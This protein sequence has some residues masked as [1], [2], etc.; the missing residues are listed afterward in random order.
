MPEFNPQKGNGKQLSGQQYDASRNIFVRFTQWMRTYSGGDAQVRTTGLEGTAG[1]EITPQDAGEAQTRTYDIAGAQAAILAI[2]YHWGSYSDVSFPDTLT[3]LSTVF[4]KTVGSGTSS[5][6]ASQQNAAFVGGGTISVNPR[7]HAQGSAAILPEVIPATKSIWGRNLPTDNY[8]FYLLG[9]APLSS[10]LGRVSGLAGQSATV[11]TITIATPGVVTWN[12]NGLANGD[13]VVFTTTGALP[14]GLL[15]NKI[16]YVV[17]VSTNTFQVA[18]T[19]GGS[20]I[21][22]TGT[23]SGVQTASKGVKQFPIFKTSDYYISSMGQQVSIAADADSIAT[24]NSSFDGSSR[25]AS[26]AYGGGASRETGVTNRITHIGPVINGL[27]NGYT[28]SDSQAVT[29]VVEASTVALVLNGTTEVT[30]ITNGPTTITA[31]A[32]S[33]IVPTSLAATSV[34]AVPTSGLYLT[35]TNSSIDEYGMLQIHAAV[36]DFSIF[37]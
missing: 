28:T 30:A 18:L 19:A 22:T 1:V 10:I 25:A 26:Y 20:A 24:L 31:T 35:E 4:N 37:A 2:V 5:H 16:Y 32:S 13:T 27:I 7:S 36:I 12:T 17:N 33:G 11:V 21:N 3:G 6:P 29:A 23:Q 8:V 14:T 15:P 9:S 34:T